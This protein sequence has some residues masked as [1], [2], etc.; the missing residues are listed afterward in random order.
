MFSK[1]KFFCTDEK[2]VD[3]SDIPDL[4]WSSWTGVLG[5][6]VEGLWHKYSDV[7]DINASDAN[8]YYNCIVTGDDYGLVKLFRFPCPK[9]GNSFIY[10]IFSC[11]YILVIKIFALYSYEQQTHLLVIMYAHL[12]LGVRVGR[13]WSRK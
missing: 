13:L 1:K 4:E 6:Q 8:F 11:K 2:V 5:P 12:T 3:E 10:H 7:S 9:R